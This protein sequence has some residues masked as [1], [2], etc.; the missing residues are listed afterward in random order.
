M[1][2][3]LLICMSNFIQFGCY[4]LFDRWTYFLYTILDYKNLKI[5]HLF[6]DIVID[7]WSSWNFASMKDR[8]RTCNPM[9]RFSNFTLNIKIYDKFERFFSKLVW[10]KTLFEVVTMSIIG[11]EFPSEIKIRF[12]GTIMHYLLFTITNFLVWSRKS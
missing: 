11:S 5:W 6:D 7:F 3:M 2:L 12:I 9:V 4:L 10:R 1:F 8:I